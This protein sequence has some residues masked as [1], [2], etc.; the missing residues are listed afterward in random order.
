MKSCLLFEAIAIHAIM[1]RN[2]RIKIKYV[3]MESITT[4]GKVADQKALE[5]IYD[6][7]FTRIIK[8]NIKEK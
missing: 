8:K 3:Y 1:S 2:K 7:I 5:S 4:E 6:D